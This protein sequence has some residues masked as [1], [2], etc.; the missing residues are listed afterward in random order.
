MKRFKKVGVDYSS[1]YFNIEINDEEIEVA[2][3]KGI[4][5]NDDYE[6]VRFYLNEHFEEYKTLLMMENFE[7]ESGDEDEIY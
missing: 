2:R 1:C 4:N 3:V 6:L 7:Y 5:I